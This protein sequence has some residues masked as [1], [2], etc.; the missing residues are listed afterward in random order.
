[1]SKATDIRAYADAALEQGRTVLTQAGAVVAGA[2]K[3]LAADGPKPAFAAVGAADLVAESVTKRVETLPTDAIA[4]LTKAPS[5][6]KARFAKAQSDAL[7]TIVELL[8]RM[9]AGVESAKSLRGVDVQGKAKDTA[10]G[11]VALAKSM[12]NALTAR[13]EAKVADL[14]KDPRL[15]KVVADLREDPRL[16]KFLAEVSDVAGTV[17][18]KVAPVLTQVEA[19]VDQVIVSVRSASPV[20]VATKPAPSQRASAKT[21]SAQPATARKSAPRKSAPTKSAPTKATARKATASKAASRTAGAAKSTARKAP[22]KKAT[23][24]A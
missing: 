3:R 7:T 2:N 19:G 23:S 6:T 5:A 17:H 9:D 13:G 4:T 1:M 14:R 24:S 22:A 18:S 11:Y 8:N 15:A 21:T 16:A 20:K 12:F 10:E